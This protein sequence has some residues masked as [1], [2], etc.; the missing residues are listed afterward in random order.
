MADRIIQ[1][2]SDIRLRSG[3]SPEATMEFLQLSSFDVCKWED[4][5]FDSSNADMD[6]RYTRAVTGSGSGAVL[7]LT[8]NQEWGSARMTTGTTNDGIS[9]MSLGTI[10]KGDYNAVMAVRFK[11]NVITAVKIEVG[12][13][14]SVANNS[15]GIVNVLNT[16]SFNATN[17]CC[18]A[19]DTDATTDTWAAE[20]VKASTASTTGETLATTAA[21]SAP[22]A[23][24]Y[25]TLV[26]AMMEDSAYFMRYNADGR[27]QGETIMLTDSQTGSTALAPSVFVQ[28]R[29]TTTKLLDIDFFKA[30]QLRRS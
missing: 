15:A 4:D 14:D 2:L 19:F 25:Q 5:F 7:T 30:W 11:I 16:P 27:K 13:R 18:W 21:G 9:A 29:N 17:G 26:V 1:D 3:D 10:F 24:T 8:A 6:N 12:F 20:G 23:D 22:V 28:T